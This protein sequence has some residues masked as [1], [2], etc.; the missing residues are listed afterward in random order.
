[1]SAFPVWFLVFSLEIA[2]RPDLVFRFRKRS[3][4]VGKCR[5]WF[6]AF[7]ATNR[8]VVVPDNGFYPQ[9]RSLTLVRVIWP[10]ILYFILVFLFFF[11]SFVGIRYFSAASYF[12]FQQRIVDL[13]IVFAHR[14][15]INYI[16]S[17]EDSYFQFHRPLVRAALNFKYL[18]VVNV[19][20]VN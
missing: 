3:T 11:Y 13:Q 6:F 16:F 18:L 15:A 20:E 19:L 2:F 10:R 14:W 1:M 17:F 4:S 9:K 8:S 5:N 12:W 7:S